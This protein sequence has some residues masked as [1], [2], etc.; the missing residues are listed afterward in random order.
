MI[1]ELYLVERRPINVYCNGVK[2]VAEPS[3]AITTPNKNGS[4][5]CDDSLK[6]LAED[7]IKILNEQSV[8]FNESLV[9]SDRQ[10]KSSYFIGKSMPREVEETGVGLITL[11][12]FNIECNILTSKT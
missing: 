7:F 2:I 12:K 3:Y 8:E 6:E 10:Y 1:Q 11:R 4:H 9:T 5:I